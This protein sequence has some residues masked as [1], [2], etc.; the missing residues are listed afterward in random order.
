MKSTQ[1]PLFPALLIVAFAFAI[2]LLG[3]ELV[4]LSIK[5]AHRLATLVDKLTPASI[6]L[7]TATLGAT[8]IAQY[9]WMVRG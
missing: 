5:A 9:C 3:L 2:F 8:A 7:A 1:S 4:K 6:A